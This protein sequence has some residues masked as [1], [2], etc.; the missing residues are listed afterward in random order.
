VVRGDAA[1]A[2][3]AAESFAAA[4]VSVVFV[5]GGELAK[6]LQA[7]RSAGVRVVL[8][9]APSEAHFE[10]A[11]ASLV[12]QR[13]G[14]LAVGNSPLFNSRRDQL[15]ALAARH[16]VAAIY[17]FR[18]FAQAGGLMSCGTSLAD[19]YRQIGLHTGRILA[20]AK[21]AD[22]PVLQPK[23]FERVVTLKTAKVLGITIPHSGC[24]APT[25]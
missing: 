11:F 24:C 2:G 17:E 7:A 22:L 15:V 25:R 18:E 4:R 16:K 14:A 10:T 23:R 5:V 19:A 3:A 6:Q 8:L 20:G 9:E 1:R 13:A 21:P 12:Q